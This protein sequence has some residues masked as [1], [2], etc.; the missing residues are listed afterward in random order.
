[1]TARWRI[2]NGARHTAKLFRNMTGLH[3]S[4]GEVHLSM[5]VGRPKGGVIMGGHILH[6]TSVVDDLAKW[7]EPRLKTP[8]AAIVCRT[9]MLPFEVIALMLREARKTRAA[10]VCCPW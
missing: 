9:S 10:G 1:M 7:R 3:S 8:V 6:F 5:A 4:L 2:Y